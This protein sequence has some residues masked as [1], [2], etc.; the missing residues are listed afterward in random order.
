MA[1][2]VRARATVTVRWPAERLSKGARGYL[3]HLLLPNAPS[4]SG[5]GPSNQLRLEI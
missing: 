1:A 2:A 4:K 3:A 5:S